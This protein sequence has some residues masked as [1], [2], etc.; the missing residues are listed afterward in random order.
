L[1]GLYSSLY[2]QLRRLSNKP[3]KMVFLSLLLFI[4]VRGLAEAE[5]FDPLLPLW[6]IALF[7][8]L[9][10]QLTRNDEQ[11]AVTFT[12][13]SSENPVLDETPQSLSTN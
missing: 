10:D 12:F 13:W 6:A 4:T 7:S 2:R 1:A 8:F 3:L 5:P 11:P 9:V